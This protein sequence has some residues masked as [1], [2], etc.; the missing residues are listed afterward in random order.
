MYRFFSLTRQEQF[1][2]AY[3]GLAK[4]GFARSSTSKHATATCLYRGPEGRKCAV[5]HLIDDDEF[6]ENTNSMGV[7]GLIQDMCCREDVHMYT[8]GRKEINFLSDLQTVHDSG[9]TPEKMQAEL[10]KFAE[11][12]GLE[13]PQS[14]YTE[15]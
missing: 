8:Y 14:V 2:R 10:S 6:I 5:G 12:Q 15:D 7:Y 4:Q 11:A 13:I 3:L 1:T 9:F